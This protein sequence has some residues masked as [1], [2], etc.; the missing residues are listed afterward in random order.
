MRQKLLTLMTKV[1]AMKNNRKT[2]S[3]PS[4]KI[5]DATET[6]DIDGKGLDNDIIRLLLQKGTDVNKRDRFGKT[7]TTLTR[8]YKQN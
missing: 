7:I 5:T 2:D 8:T 3:S 1:S 4:N 6:I